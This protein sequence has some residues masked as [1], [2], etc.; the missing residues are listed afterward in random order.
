VYRQIE[1]SST[2]YSIV[3]KLETVDVGPGFAEITAVA[4][5]GFPRD[6]DHCA[7]ACGLLTQPTILF[8]LAPAMVEHE[9][10]GAL[11]APCCRY[12]VTWNHEP[13]GASAESDRN[14][15]L[16]GQLEAMKERLHGILRRLLI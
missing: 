4:V 9:Q 5:D 14:S 7:W 12:R 8:G 16:V 2:K 3:T 11:G 1:T 15:T 10:C 6:S 13:T